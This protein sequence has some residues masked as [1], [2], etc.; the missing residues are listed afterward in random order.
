MTRR[1]V[2]LAA[3]PMIL[4]L[5]TAPP[6]IGSGDPAVPGG[7]KPPFEGIGI[8]QRLGETIPGDLTFTDETGRPV[9]LADIAA[10]GPMVLTFAYFRCPMLCS[11]VRTGL[12]SGLD[13][14]GLRAGIDY[15]AVTISIDPLDTPAMAAAAKK[16]MAARNPGL[17]A[18]GA[19]RFLTGDEAAIRTA[20]RAAGFRYMYDPATGQYAHAAG[21]VVVTSTGKIAQY[22]LGIDY[23]P[24]DL[25]L[26][27]V[28]ASEGK[29]GTLVDRLTLLCYQYDPATGHYGFTIYAIVRIG[30]V[31]TVTAL[32]VWMAI[33]FRREARAARIRRAQ[34]V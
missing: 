15:T 29:I 12:A 32:A 31:L 6:A 33:M 19:W 22:L 27:L 2:L 5:A 28:Q 30:G 24:R 23:A 11:L 26:A 34:G 20:T 17:G 4:L 18:E 25:R 1:M 3:A 10:R 9:R 13:V 8:D 7:P 16:E 14:A 21:A